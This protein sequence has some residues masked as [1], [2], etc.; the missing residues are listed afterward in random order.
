LYLSVGLSKSIEAVLLRFDYGFYRST[1][2]NRL[3]PI[4][5]HRFSFSTTV[6]LGKA[7]YWHARGSIEQSPYLQRL[8][9]NT[10]LQVRF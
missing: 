3:D 7:L 10:S 8:S 6:P 9:L 1:N 5:L 2:P 4:D